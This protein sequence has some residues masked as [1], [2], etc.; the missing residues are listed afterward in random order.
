ML[1]RPTGTTPNTNSPFASDVARP[2]GSSVPA[3][4]RR[5]PTPGSAA[6]GPPGSRVSVL[7]DVAIAPD[8]ALA[9]DGDETIPGLTRN[10]E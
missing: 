6:S 1:Y 9:G 4:T 10:S 3:T 7:V 5:T 2:I 8:E